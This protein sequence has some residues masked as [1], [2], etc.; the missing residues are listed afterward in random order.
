MPRKVFANGNPLPASDLNTYLMDQSVMTFADSAA[1]SAAIPSP[2]E[3]MITY[4]NDTNKV[5]VYTGSP[6][7]WTDI[8][9]NS[10]AIP[11]SVVTTTGDLIVGNG[12]ASVTRLG[13]GTNGQVLSSNGTTATW[14]TP[15][16]GGGV[17]LLASGNL[18]G[19]SVSLTSISQ[20]YKNL[21]LQV[22]AVGVFGS[23][24]TGLFNGSTYQNQTYG[25]SF[26]NGGTWSNTVYINA[27]TAVFEGFQT[28][29]TGSGSMTWRY[30]DYTSTGFR[31]MTFYGNPQ[32]TNTRV[33]YGGGGI[34]SGSAINRIDIYAG[35]TTFYGGTYKL[36]GEK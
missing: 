23:F 15:A 29:T 2:T 22:Q 30:Q 5:E 7:A 11:K 1:R 14:T 9:D 31:P 4:L 12:N 28:G 13:I 20:D 19:S 36:W 8:N 26:Y 21:I 35:G 6:L 17:T 16:G 24:Q 32:Y 27:N 3:G 33:L 25:Y 34:N 10:A 18:T